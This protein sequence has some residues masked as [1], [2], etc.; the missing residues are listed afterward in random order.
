MSNTTRASLVLL[1]GV[2]C[3]GFSPLFVK[4]ANAPGAV[5]GFYRMLGAVIVFALPFSRRMQE[6]RSGSRNRL[7]RREIAVAMLGGFFFAGDLIF[8]NTGI[9]I[10]GATNPTLMGNTA[11]LWVGLGAMIFFHEKLPTM[12]WVGLLATLAG[13]AL[14]LG[15]DAARSLTLGMGTLL[16]LVAG[17]FYGGYF[18]V[19]QRSREQ[20][21]ALSYF[22]IAASSATVLLFFAAL[23]LDQALLGYPALTYLNFLA[24]ALVVQVL[25]QFSFSYSLGFLPAS[26]VA[27]AGL[28]QPVV[29]ALLAWLLLG[30]PITLLQAAG[31]LT[32]LAGVFIVHRSRQLPAE[33]PDQDS[34]FSASS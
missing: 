15:L 13:A 28:G 2:A 33:P 24:L 21:D 14:I 29:A 9:L 12:F 11:P 3:L 17:V 27:P 22:W 32:V 26:V 34:D 30:E 18:L 19:T 23:L 25:G 1:F 31:G 5:T 6:R 16:G 4:W 20:L 8:W 10:G 7:P